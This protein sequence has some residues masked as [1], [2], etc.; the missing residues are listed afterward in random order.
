MT[1]ITLRNIASGYNLSKINSNFQDLEAVIN[2]SVLHRYGNNNTMSQ[3]L[4]MNGYAI[5]NLPKP[6]SPTQ[7]LRLQDL[8]SVE[9]LTL[10]KVG[11]TV[12]PGQ[13]VYSVSNKI[14]T[15]NAVF[16]NGK[17]QHQTDNA[18]SIT[19]EGELS[20]S[21][22]LFEGDVLE[23]WNRLVV[24]TGL[25]E[26]L[27]TGVYSKTL[28]EAVYFSGFKHGDCVII[29][30][31]VNGIF[32]LVD[33]SSVTPNGY[34][35]V[36]C[37]GNSTLAL[38]LRVS[39]EINLDMFGVPTDSDARE[40]I[41][42]AIDLAESRDT[43]S[44][45]TSE[46]SVFTLESTSVAPVYGGN[47]GLS[48][49]NVR[50]VNLNLRGGKIQFNKDNIALGLIPKDALLALTSTGE[51]SNNAFLRITNSELSG[52]NFADPTERPTNVVKADYVKMSYGFMEDNLFTFAKEDVFKMNGF[53]M[54]F[55][56]VR[57]RY[58]GA[59]GAGFNL[60][61][62]SGANTGYLLSGCT[63]DFAGLFGFYIHGSSGHTYCALNNCHADFIGQDD[64]KVTREE[65]IGES[66]AYSIND[67]RVVNLNAC[68]AEFC[69]ASF[70]GRNCRSLSIDG[71]FTL[72]MGHSDGSTELDSNCRIT[73]FFEQVNIR[74]FE[75][76]SPKGGGYD[77]ILS[78]QNP[79]QF[80]LNNVTVDGSI[81]T[82]SIRYDG[83]NQS[84]SQTPL[85]TSPQDL[86]LSQNRR[87]AGD[88]VR[89][90]TKMRGA[91]DTAWYN[92]TD[93]LEQTF[94]TN[95]SDSGEVKE[96]L[97]IDEAN[98]GVMAFVVDII[99][100]RSTSPQVSEYKGSA[101]YDSTTMTLVQPLPNVL[102]VSGDLPTLDFTGGTLSLNLPNTFCG[103]YVKVT[104]VQRPGSNYVRINW[105]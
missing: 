89:T 6:T 93:V 53:V 69:N 87:G 94:F 23:I 40:G 3:E 41:Q 26:G 37:V 8:E 102:L 61:T 44:T 21:E 77:A 98:G 9:L 38:V 56:K 70:V 48:I 90:G 49:T 36:R 11:L 1:D 47:V 99:S 80:N 50:R 76:R 5:L 88:I 34:N 19:P 22:P 31:R 97:S 58:A 64:N 15:E 33:A 85:V 74:N 65:N 51:G 92:A 60:I 71:L 20:L 75:N 95:T 18:Y 72:G 83:G 45:I 59:S 79:D 12:V 101:H 7:P 67:V 52:G 16:I 24:P 13:L 96:L 84:S 100:V 35:I 68:G 105:L 104:A 25:Q 42:A 82:S 39:A 10:E 66:F 17:M 55:T 63:S 54:V 46:G 57:C 4:D 81:S 28:E 103:Y 78:L 62:S 86:Y 91:S 43:T 32:D 29:S 30:D 27:S 73:G 14:T 2:D